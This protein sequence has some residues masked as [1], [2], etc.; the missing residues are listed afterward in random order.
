MLYGTP[1]PTQSGIS[2]LTQELC[3]GVLVGQVVRDGTGAC[4]QTS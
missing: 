3:E 4:V 1:C 2:R